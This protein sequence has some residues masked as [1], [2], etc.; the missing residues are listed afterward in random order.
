MRNKFLIKLIKEEANKILKELSSEDALW[1]LANIGDIAEGYVS[2]AVAA[3]FLYPTRNVNV[4]DM[5]KVIDQLNEN[6]DL[7]A[8]KTVKKTTKFT[9]M[10]NPD[11]L[12]A[13]D[14]D[15]ELTI[16]LSRTNF[17][18]FTN[19]E[20]IKKSIKTINTTLKFANSVGVSEL[21][22]QSFDDP[23]KNVI[24]ISSVGT[25]DQKGTKIDIKIEM[26]GQLVPWGR[27]SLKA[28][29]TQLG[30]IGKSWEL[31][32]NVKRSSRGIVDLFK[33]LFGV[34]VSSNLKK[35]YLE[36]I[37]SKDYKIIIDAV[38]AVYH[39][40]Y[41]KITNKFKS[42]DE[43]FSFLETLA[44]GVRYEAMLEEE[45]VVLLDLSNSDFKL[46][47]FDKLVN[48]FS[49]DDL[50]IELEV[51]YLPSKEDY[52]TLPKLI[53]YAQVNGK[54]YG[55]LLSVRPKIRSKGEFRHY[56]QKDPGL[57]KLISM[58]HD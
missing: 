1:H 36:A 8:T 53:F 38:E 26:D 46:I 19:F 15:I 13:K 47:N 44:K 39:D 3:K 55:R 50:E 27:I 56:V 2:A 16:G 5:F 6:E 18:A 37:K 7:S 52:S 30:Q 35:Q 28:G 45:G 40:A 20:F 33:G 22:R 48:I 54:N 21:A 24:S 49:S 43:F 41:R 9:R 12:N 57:S 14:D 4:Q 32:P 17:E 25:E 23:D 42:E 29:S 11:V 51:E 31:D 10:S 58:S 34:T